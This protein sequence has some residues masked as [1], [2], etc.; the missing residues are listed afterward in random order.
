MFV[1]GLEREIYCTLTGIKKKR[2]THIHTQRGLKRRT[3]SLLFA[4]CKH[5]RVDFKAVL[6][7]RQANFEGWI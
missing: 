4:Y 3:S 6:A 1:C 2:E 5:E 7:G